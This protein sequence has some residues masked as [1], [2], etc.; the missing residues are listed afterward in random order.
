MIRNSLIAAMSV[1]AVIGSC[2]VAFAADEAKSSPAPAAGTT[3]PAASTTA[4]KP[5]KGH[6]RHCTKKAGK[7]AK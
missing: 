7:C 6:K 5:V 4:K 1:A 3:A 2:A